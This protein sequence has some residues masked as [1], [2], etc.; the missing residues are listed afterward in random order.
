MIFPYEI[1]LTLDEYD[2][3]EHTRYYF[4]KRD[5]SYNGKIDF[6]HASGRSR[7]IDTELIHST[8]INPIP[9][10]YYVGSLSQNGG[11]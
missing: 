11:I 9:D 4:Y 5:I 3:F 1:T 2:F 7:H 10:S 8:L 6:S